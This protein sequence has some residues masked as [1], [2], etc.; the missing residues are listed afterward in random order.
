[1]KK[2]HQ[3]QPWKEKVKEPVKARPKRR[4]PEEEEESAILSPGPIFPRAPAV[5]DHQPIPCS[6]DKGNRQIL[7]TPTPGFSPREPPS[8]HQ[9]DAMYHPTDSPDLEGKW[10]TPESPPLT[11]YRAHVQVLHETP[12]EELSE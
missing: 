10:N 1:M 5:E 6:P 12:G 9:R 8:N 11:R 7:D 2:A 3:P 4:Q